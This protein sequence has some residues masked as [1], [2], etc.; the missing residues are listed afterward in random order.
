MRLVLTSCDCAERAAPFTECT[1]T[2][3]VH[4]GVTVPVSHGVNN[5]LGGLVV[6]HP[7]ASSLQLSSMA[8][9]SGSEQRGY[10]M[11][12]TGWL[13]LLLLLLVG[14][15]MFDSNSIQLNMPQDKS[16]S[17]AFSNIW[18]NFVFC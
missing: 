17:L 2:A 11:H 1:C 13:L 12:E 7:P 9:E 8:G 3:R 6:R 14:M 5:V 18:D 4:G 10:A 15:T 16:S